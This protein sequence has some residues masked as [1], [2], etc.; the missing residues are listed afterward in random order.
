MSGL[1][2]HLAHSKCS[3]ILAIIFTVIKAITTD[4][5]SSPLCI[6]VTVNS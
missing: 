3:I 6:D 2:E 4:F 5:C 1:A